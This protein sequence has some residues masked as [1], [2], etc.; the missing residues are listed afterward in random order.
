MD[1]RDGHLLMGLKN[2]TI[3]ELKEGQSEPRF[4][5]QSHFMGE[6]WGMH[7]VD[8]S[9]VVTCGDDNR[10]M[11]FDTDKKVLAQGAAVSK[12]A[13]QDRKNPDNDKHCVAVSDSI[14]KPNKQARGIATSLKHAHVVVCNNVG[15]ISIRSLTDLQTKVASLKQAK[16][17]CTAIAFSPC[18][19]F[20]AVGSH[21]D[22][23]YIY[24]ID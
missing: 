6:V 11:L 17:H 4:I 15:K 23:L 16:K 22:H 7:V 19:N 1:L 8:N 24:R 5:L 9:R 13:D 14:F 12:K 21:D 10:I 18:E 2:G 20:L 3:I